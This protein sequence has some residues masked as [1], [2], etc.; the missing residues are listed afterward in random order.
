MSLV[1]PLPQEVEDLYNRF[2]EAFSEGTFEDV[3]ALTHFE[4]PLYR[5]MTELAFD[6]LPNPRLESWEKLNDQLW[7]A[8]TSYDEDDEMVAVDGR[9]VA[10]YFVGEVDGQ[11]RVMI[12]IFQVPEELLDGVDT[13]RFIGENTLIPGQFILS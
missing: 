1:N 7:V 12:G 8:Y 13:S 10:D 3:D 2:I 5:E 6:N 11:L 9:A 4:I